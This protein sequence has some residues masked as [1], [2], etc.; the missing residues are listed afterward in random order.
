MGVAQ[1]IWQAFIRAHPEAAN[2]QLPLEDVNRKM[3]AFTQARNQQPHPDFEGISPEQMHTLLNDP[4]GTGSVIQLR[5]NQTDSLLDQIPFFV[6]METLYQHLLTDDFIKLTPKGNL[7]LAL[8]RSLYERKLLVQDDIERGITKKICEDNVRFLQALKACLSLSPYVKKRQNAFSLT[9][10][11]HQA[12][13]KERGLLFRQVL[14]DYTLRFNWGYLDDTPTDAGHFGWA[15]SLYL[16]YRY[17]SGWRDT[18]FY[19]AKLT[20]A[21][22]HLDEPIASDR[23]PGYSL[24]FERVYR[25]RFVEQFAAWFGLIERRKESQPGLYDAPLQLQKTPLFDQLFYFTV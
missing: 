15:Y 20:A 18:D 6:L 10:S 21:F 2:G 7:P 1:E 3:A 5:D 17:G 8:C 23:V 4:W 16:V 12:L 25:W 19:A 14:Q 22:P 13:A 11:G 9:K 24:E